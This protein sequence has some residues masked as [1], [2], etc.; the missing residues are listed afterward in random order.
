MELF[1]GDEGKIVGAEGGLEA[2]AVFED[3]LAGIPFGEAEIQH[4]GAGEFADSSR[5][6]AETVDQPGKFAEGRNFED[7]QTVNFAFAPMSGVWFR[8]AG[9]A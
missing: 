9:F 3:V 4:L 8:A 1:E 2:A 7:S 6:S 5:K